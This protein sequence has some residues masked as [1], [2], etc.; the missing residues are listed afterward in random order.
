MKMRQMSVAAPKQGVVVAIYFGL[1]AI[2]LIS[3]VIAIATLFSV[4]AAELWHHYSIIFMGLLA[5]NTWY[6]YVLLFMADLAPEQAAAPEDSDKLMSIIVPCY[7]EDLD[8]FAKAI[9]SVLRAKGRKEIIII[10]DGSPGNCK[11]LTQVIELHPDVKVHLF[12][13]NQGKREALTYAVR[14]LVSPDSYCCITIDSDTIVAPD[15]FLYLQ[16]ALE[17]PR[18]AA[19]TGDVL[20]TNE[21][22]NLLTRMIGSYYW[23]GLNIYKQAQSAIGTV[24]CC[25]GCLAAYKT[26][27]LREIIDEF[28]EQEFL[29]E[30]C[31]HSEDRHLTNLTLRRGYK[32]TFVP[33]AK[34]YT[35]TPDTLHGFIKQ[36]LRWKRGYVRES[37]Y[38]LSYAWK[39]QKRLFFQLL[40]WDLTA[41]FLSVGLHLQLLLLLILDPHF[42]LTMI[43]PLWAIA[44]VLRYLYVFIKAPRKVPG[45][46]L[47][48]LL[49]E[50]LLY[51]IN[52]YALF[53]VKNK[54]W[55][56]RTQPIQ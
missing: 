18:V 37:V 34:S 10:D 44:I 47:Y 1:W 52:V 3:L 38:T 26:D 5:L 53:T 25:S 29:G 48:G 32:V 46:F 20:L 15:A 16:Q 24:V 11:N 9:H 19:A 41:T 23:I 51:W 45:V 4:H 7:N 43:L 56:T 54:S 21:T 30:R 13:N 39:N 17:D 40:S 28:H 12:S 27:V 42:V 33:N 22:S 50:G 6:V 55:V 35:E 2:V 8:L 49:F 36:Q 31:T 14:N